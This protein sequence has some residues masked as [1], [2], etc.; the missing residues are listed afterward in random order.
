MGDA[1]CKMWNNYLSG[2][3]KLSSREQAQTNQSVS[4]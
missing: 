4:T 2:E 3:K 1:A